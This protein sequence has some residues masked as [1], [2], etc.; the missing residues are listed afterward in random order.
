MTAAL[1]Q[2]AAACKT[3]LDLAALLGPAAWAQLPAA[4][5]RRFAAG[6][7]DTQYRGAMDLRR[8][9]IGWL[10]AWL[11]KP[12]ASPLVACQAN[13]LVA[14]VR[15]H[16]N[17]AGGMVWERRIGDQLVASTKELGRDGGLQERTAGGLGMDLD[18][19]VEQGE[20]VFRSRRYWLQIAGLRLPLPGLLGPGACEVRHADLGGGR[21]RFSLSMRHPLWGETF[22]QTGVFADPI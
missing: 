21:F 14:V 8:S 1:A 22:H 19:A 20:L 10:Y 7:P 16:P 13:D 9:R 6:H 18:L 3:P 11:T 17:A 5:Q 15:A 4:V 2:P 12:L